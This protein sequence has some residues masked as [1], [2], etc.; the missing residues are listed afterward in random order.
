MLYILTFHDA[1]EELLKP[2]R[3][4]N[5][6]IAGSYFYVVTL[7]AATLWVLVLL[8]PASLKRRIEYGLRRDHFVVPA[9]L[10]LFISS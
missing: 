7:I 4:D 8:P 3:V 9:A 5:Q 6:P 10:I 1:A 2:I